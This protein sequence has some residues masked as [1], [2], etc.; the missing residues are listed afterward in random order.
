[1]YCNNEVVVCTSG[2]VHADDTSEIVK[3]IN[4]FKPKYFILWQVGE[5]NAPQFKTHLNH[6]FK[7]N[8][9]NEDI[10][11][12]EKTLVEN[13]TIFYLVLGCEDNGIDF[14]NF[15]K[16]PISNF[17]ILFWPTF[18]LH[19]TYYALKYKY[20]EIPNIK[21]EKD[22][23]KLYVNYN[24]K[25]K[26]HRAK[27]L[28]ELCR[29]DLIKYGQIS[30][31]GTYREMMDYTFNCWDEKITKIDNFTLPIPSSTYSENLLDLDVLL[32]LV[33]E[34]SYFHA[35]IFITEK[36]FKPILLNQIFIVIGA[37]NQ[38]KILTK[39]GFL[40]FDELFDYSY[41]NE[42]ELDKRITGVVENLLKLKDSNY[43][44]IYN[45]V[46]YKL[47]HNRNRAIEIVKN[48]P[49]FPDEIVN[50]YK[51]YGNNFLKLFQEWNRTYRDTYPFTKEINL[52]DEIIKTKIYDK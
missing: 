26:I 7:D 2:D 19:Y 35:S 44:E 47:N 16:Y 20:G 38:N 12:F 9:K 51:I 6:N 8:E 41:E 14:I 30:W 52:F 5:S 10:I 22:I 43:L 50:L 45:K 3:K 24:N 29:K 33:S 27:L 42:I 46:C 37:C 25:S 21:L 13:N 11:E 4:E 28:D 34:T 17:K 40:I 1:M 23:D 49:F 15:T 32:N 39:Y 31:H 36:T 48:D 18:L